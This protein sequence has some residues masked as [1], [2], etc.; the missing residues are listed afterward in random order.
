M[1]ISMTKRWT[2]I[3]VSSIIIG[4]LTGIVGFAFHYVTELVT[5]FRKSNSYIIY[6]LPVI[7]LF[8]AYMYRNDS[9]NLNT[10]G[11]V[12][13]A[14]NNETA[15]FIVAPLIFISATLTHLFGGSAGREGAAL[16]LGGGIS[17]KVSKWFR[18]DEDVSLLI[19]SG[20]SG[21]FAS[22]F[23]TPVTSVVFA[24]EFIGFKEISMLSFIPCIISSGISFF[25]AYLLGT[26]PLIF[27]FSSEKFSVSLLLK[28]IVVACLCALVSFV[29]C[30]FMHKVGFLAKKIKNPYYRVFIGGIIVVIL[31]VIYGSYD[32]NGVG[33]DVI[34]NAISGN[35]LSEAFLLK[36][37]L[38]AFT[39]E[40]GFKGG[41][42]VPSLFIGATFGGAVAS[43]IGL[44]IPFGASL[45]MICLF[46]G[47][48]NC[49]IASLI[50]AS[51]V[52]RGNSVL[53]FAVAC[54]ICYILSGEVALYDKRRRI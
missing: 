35:V 48:T 36:M 38:T 28:V 2:K 24:V 39:L 32:Y 53:L 50:L 21:C 37:I 49:P 44:S 54:A 20:M 12:V 18:C 3:I 19:A 40:F 23:A 52:F 51:E 14:R 1:V 30:H 8:I 7:G 34:K 31:T 41:E 9:G 16:Q 15:P 42:V 46:C 47:I 13:S 45:G 10:N 43:I 11:I 6:F 17:S 29:F 25:V 27:T 26:K 4:I 33:M 5:D 22:V